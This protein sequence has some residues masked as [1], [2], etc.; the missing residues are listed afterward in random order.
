MLPH[1]LPQLTYAGGGHG[2]H[3]AWSNHEEFF[4]VAFAELGMTALQRPHSITDII[5]G[6]MAYK[7][8]VLR[9]ASWWRA[10]TAVR[11]HHGRPAP[12]S[13]GAEDARPDALPRVETR[14]H[15][16]VVFRV[17]DVLDEQDRKTRGP[18]PLWPTALEENTGPVQR[19]LEGPRAPPPGPGQ[20]K[21]QLISFLLVAMAS[22]TASTSTSSC[23]TSA[24]SMPCR[25]A[26]SSTSLCS[27]CAV[28]ATV[29]MALR[30][31]AATPSPHRWGMS[32][33]FAFVFL[34]A[35]AL[36]GQARWRSGPPPA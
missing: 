19:L 29:K 2:D 30:I 31:T 1:E 27:C 36:L 12:R 28:H 22:T 17:E 33:V 16:R 10:S 13:G 7:A 11:A 14:K 18:N 6:T 24:T 20:I 21:Q 9:P 15:R 4:P 3:A 34:H 35:P 8:E 23:S 5:P 26:R 32:V 25:A